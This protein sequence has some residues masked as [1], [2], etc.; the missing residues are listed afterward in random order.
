MMNGQLHF[1]SDTSNFNEQ[2][3]TELKCPIKPCEFIKML[4][5]FEN[6]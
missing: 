4:I 5:Y 6:I 3:S 1:N 2:N